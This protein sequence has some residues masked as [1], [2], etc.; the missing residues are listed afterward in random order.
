MGRLGATA[1][2]LG[3]DFSASMIDAIS[4]SENSCTA[5]RSWFTAF[6]SYL[7]ERI[8]QTPRAKRLASADQRRS[9]R[10]IRPPSR[11]H[12]RCR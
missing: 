9:V 3:L 4:A 10:F 6:D 1:F 8:A 5:P 11:A 7:T 2:S 12:T